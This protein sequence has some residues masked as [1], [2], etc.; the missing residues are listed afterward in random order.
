MQKIVSI[1]QIKRN[2]NKFIITLDN[3][4]V[5]NLVDEAI[6][7]YGLYVGKEIDE[8]K[9]CETANYSE[10]TEAFSRALKTLEKSFKT[11]KE[12]FNLLK[13]KGFQENA[14]IEAIKKLK[15]YNYV[16]DI[17]FAK[18]FVASVSTHKGKKLIEY[19]LKQ[20]GV[21]ENIISDAVSLLEDEL[22][23]ILVL[24]KKF[25]KNKE[26]CKEN[27]AKL[28]RHL[29]SKGFKYEDIKNAIKNLE[30]EIENEDWN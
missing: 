23:T 24:A 9:L 30:L 4:E 25:M 19:E 15:E 27:L 3:G 5:F 6:V 21:D 22:D 13:E 12:I 7:K 26:N 8:K 2:K 20:K 28:I 17:E 10:K 29:M 18:Q 14:I 1:E 16:S 11:E